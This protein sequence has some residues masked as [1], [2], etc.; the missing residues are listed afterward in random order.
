M[1]IRNERKKATANFADTEFLFGKKCTFE[2]AF[3]EIQD[4]DVV[5]NETDFGNP[6][7]TRHYTRSDPPG[8]YL[9]CRNSLCYNGGVC[10]GALIR[11][12]VQNRETSLQERRPCQGYEG[13]P[14]GRR[15]YR[16]C[17]H[18]FEVSIKLKYKKDQ[19]D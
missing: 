12:L 6:V 1:T 4:I 16:S 15:K 2:E 11:Q 17:L 9:D 19:R 13:S 3:P 7:R 5:V 10:I 14:K 8:E 18:Y